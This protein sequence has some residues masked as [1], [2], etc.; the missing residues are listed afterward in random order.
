LTLPTKLELTDELA[1]LP[2][3]PRPAGES[4][5]KYATRTVKE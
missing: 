4:T 3:V 5:Y 1:E 2:P